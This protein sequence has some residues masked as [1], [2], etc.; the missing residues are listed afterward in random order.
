MT[1][2]MYWTRF[3]SVLLLMGDFNARVDCGGTGDDVWVG[4]RGRHGVGECN[5]A[6]QRFL[7]FCASNQYTIMNTWF[8]KKQHHLTTWKHPATKQMHMID[9]I[10]MR[11]DQR[12]LC[13]DVQVMRGANCWSDHRMVR[14]KMRLRL[15]RWKKA[16][17]GTWPIAVDALRRAEISQRYQQKLKEH[18]H[19]HP[20]VSNGAVE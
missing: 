15:P 1:Y 14:M 17:L 10:V 11:A 13:T 19:E 16:P 6:G 2:R 7:E 8:Q 12:C 4:V 18:L 20:H 9:Y 5:G 3:H